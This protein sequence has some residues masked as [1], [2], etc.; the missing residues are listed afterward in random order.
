MSEIDTE[1]HR[2]KGNISNAFDA[3]EE[4]G[5]TVPE[6]RVSGNLAEA[7]RSLQGKDFEAELEAVKAA[8]V[9]KSLAG[10]TVEPVQGQM[11]QAGSGA[12]IF[13]DYR[14]RAFTSTGS[15]NGGNIATGAYAHAEGS[16]TTAK[17]NY[18]HAEGECSVASGG[19][20]SHAE[21]SS[22]T[23]SGDASHAEGS[24]TAAAG[25]RS[26]AEGYLSKTEGSAAN[27]HAEGYKTTVSGAASHAEGYQTTAS[28]GSSHAEGSD[29]TAS[30]SSSHA[31]GKN[32]I[33][34][35]TYSH[36]EGWQTTASGK[37]SHAG[38]EGCLASAWA[39]ATFGTYNVEYAGTDQ[40]TRNSNAIFI[41]G[42]GISTARANAFRIATTGVFA[43]GNYNA[44]GADYA[45]L[46][47]WA[48]GNP[49]NEDRVG[50]FVTL[51][52][53]RIALAGPEENFI[54]GI[55]SGA[56]SVVGNA[57]DDQWQGMYL[58]DV[59]GRPLWEDV[60]VPAQLGP[61]GEVIAEA[62]TEHRQ[63][64]NPAYD[65]S[66]KYQPRSQ[67]PEWDAVGMLGKLVVEDD[68]SCVPDSWCRPG[69]QGI[70]VASQERTRWRVMSRLDCSHVKVLIL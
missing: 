54:L 41:V 68:G 16:S 2:I 30:G 33:A 59:F 25:A 35:G 24:T 52:G 60:E 50:R 22:A 57:H 5:G 17:G 9:G 34:S 40:N 48:D 3:V 53:D 63:K 18:S 7:V 62:H 55:V 14:A 15:V 69:L 31:E 66:Q 37:S 56:P 47:E 65:S 32:N 1:I 70:A 46:F 21:G 26:H 61:D 67:R 28:G 51:H 13:N 8:M 45:E 23:A 44:T 27:S 19:Y 10:Q 58:Y 49:D 42:K 11:V 6:E 20:G 29:T 39:Q 38:G 43:S 12:E 64:L 4:M 36:A